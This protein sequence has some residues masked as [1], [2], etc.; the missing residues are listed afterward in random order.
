MSERKRNVWVHPNPQK[1]ILCDTDVKNEGEEARVG[2]LQA[3]VT[4]NVLRGKWEGAS[5]EVGRQE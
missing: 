5:H 1:S 4:L 3:R 2:D